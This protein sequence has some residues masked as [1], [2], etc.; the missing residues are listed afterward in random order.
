MMHFVHVDSFF[1]PTT[2]IQL[3]YLTSISDTANSDKL[4]IY[5]AINA[6]AQT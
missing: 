3:Q 1:L 6:Y 5:Q 4:Q 2:E